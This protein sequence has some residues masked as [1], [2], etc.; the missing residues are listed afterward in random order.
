MLRSEEFRPIFSKI[1][2]SF[3]AAIFMLQI[4]NKHKIYPAIFMQAI[5]YTIIIIMT[6]IDNK[7]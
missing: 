7:I 2:Y 5:R 1:K 6:R 3:Y 4:L